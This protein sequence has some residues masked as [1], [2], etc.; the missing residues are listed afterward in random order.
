MPFEKVG[1]RASVEGVSQYVRDAGK[2]ERSTT[3]MSNKVKGVAPSFRISTTQAL[4]FGAALVGVQLGI[5]VMSRSVVGLQASTVG[6]A[7]AFESSFAGIRKTMDLTEDQFDSLARANRDLALEIPVTAN[8]LNRIGELAGQ[9]GVRGVENVVKFEETIAK[10]AVTTDL[11]A[12]SAAISLAQFANILQIPQG[13]VENLGSAIVGLGN[14]FATT[15]SR[16]VDFGLRIAGAGKIAGLTAGEVFGIGAAF[17]SVGVPAERGGT[18]IQQ[19]LIAMQKAVVEGGAELE[20]FAAVAGTT[21]EE[22]AALFKEDAAEAF[23]LFVEG[24]GLAGDQGFEILDALGLAGQRLIGSF[25]SVAGAGDMLRDAIASG[26]EQFEANIA[27]Q[28]EADTR[29]ATTSSQLQILRN[30]FADIGIAGGEAALDG[31]LPLIEAT[32]DWLDT[33]A[34]EFAQDLQTA[35]VGVTNAVN[36]LVEVMQTLADFGPISIAIETATGTIALLADILGLVTKATGAPG[37]EERILGLL[38]EQAELREAIALLDVP[39]ER[40]I[41]LPEATEIQRQELET[42]L[43]F[44]QQEL[45]TLLVR[46]AR[47]PV[48]ADLAD[49]QRVRGFVRELEGMRDA[50][51]ELIAIQET[52]GAPEAALTERLATINRQIELRRAQL[53][54]LVRGAPRPERPEE[55]EEP[56]ERE[57]R[58]PPTD[59]ELARA[60]K[61]L[62]RLARDAE[63]ARERLLREGLAEV[64]LFAGLVVSALRAR[65]QAELDIEQDKISEIREAERDAHDVRIREIDEALERKLDAIRRETEAEEGRIDAELEGL[66]EE[67]DA[68]RLVALERDLALAFEEDDVFE[69]EQRIADFRRRQRERELRDELSGVR[70]AGRDREQGARDLARDEIEIARDELAEELRL[71]DER[72]EAARVSFENIT[73][74]WRTEAEARRLILAEENEEIA[75]LLEA[76]GETWRTAGI[77]LGAQMVD[78]IR[79]ELDTFIASA[80]ANVPGTGAAAAAA[81]QREIDLEANQQAGVD[82]KAAGVPAFVLDSMRQFVI[83][84]FGTTPRFQRGG[85]VGAGGE[86]V[87][88]D[89]EPGELVLNP[90]QQGAL[91]GG[92][93][94]FE[95]GAFEGMFRGAAFDGSPEENGREVARAFE[96]LMDEQLGRGAFIRGVGS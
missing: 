54:G 13:R 15:E 46:R 84:N 22:F 73:E 21:V 12:E 26:N 77:T 3:G 39:G 25:L 1:V 60:R 5:S 43:A 29:F 57:I 30:R 37:E 45:E 65:A 95:A 67:G 14:T 64:D 89:V 38:Q 36:G 27:L 4:R 92:R 50:T 94:I 81:R 17:A 24:L 93:T 18:A 44:I 49:I 10:L 69:A 32:T 34:D 8:E 68:D 61:A 87:S 88:I 19:S 7:I 11:T 16:I 72:E 86:R 20:I 47:R 40:P 91:L 58:L 63:R 35:I 56:E 78:G 96:A 28:K 75:R 23:V 42:I 83:D 33:N 6:A 66:R 59:A 76:Q 9:L 41:F 55:E 80:F 90:V 70:E 82:A 51:L 2:I 31:L 79:S 71:L 48:V 52:T 74:D 62:E 53:E 85:F